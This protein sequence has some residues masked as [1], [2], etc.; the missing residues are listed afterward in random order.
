MI[1]VPKPYM[2]DNVVNSK[3]K[4]FVRRNKTTIIAVTATAVPLI[5]LNV[6]FFQ[7][8]RAWAARNGCH[9]GSNHLHFTDKTA[10]LVVDG[11]KWGFGWDDKKIKSSGVVIMTGETYE[12]E[13]GIVKDFLKNRGLLE[14]FNESI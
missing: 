6:K 9:D 12:K 2:K 5:V 1:C 3:I 14:E 8:N 4:N 7:A 13:W 11:A 10:K